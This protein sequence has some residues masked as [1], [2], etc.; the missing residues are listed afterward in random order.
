MA[1]HLSQYRHLVADAG[2][3]LKL[4]LLWLQPVAIKMILKTDQKAQEDFL[5]EIKLL[6]HVSLDANV[7]QYFGASFQH[8]QLWLVTEYMEVSH[9]SVRS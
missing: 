3:T 1:L 5:K 4:L 9:S 8:D 2:V 7:V 6:K